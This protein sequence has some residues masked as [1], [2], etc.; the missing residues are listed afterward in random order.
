VA[1]GRRALAMTERHEHIWGHA[2]AC[3]LL[4]GTLLVTGD[5]AEAIVLFERGLAAAQEAGVE[6][7]RLRCAA[8]LA[9]VTGSAEVLAEATRL[10]E[11]ATIPAEGAWL[12]GDEAYLSLAAAWLRR[13]DPE[14]A[15]DLLTPLLAVAERAP[16]MATLGAALVA[17]G[18]ALATLGERERAGRTLRRAARLADEHRLVHV[19]QDARA[20]LE[21]LG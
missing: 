10:L 13:G 18:R 9:A 7:Y 5:R 12:P 8:P 14:R 16:W 3:A 17:D 19:Q 21:D 15:R 11:Q 1:V 6:A 20:A 4:G 2:L